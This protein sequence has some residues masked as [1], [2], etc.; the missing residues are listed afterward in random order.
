MN[1][2]KQTKIAEK[3][4]SLL[5][6]G[7]GYNGSKEQAIKEIVTELQSNSLPEPQ[8]TPA[9]RE[10]FMEKM[11]QIQI[12][13]YNK[14]KGSNEADLFTREDIAD[15]VATLAQKEMAKYETAAAFQ[16]HTIKNLKTEIEQQQ[17]ETARLALLCQ[18]RNE[19]ITKLRT[20]NESLVQVAAK[21]TERIGELQ[22]EQ[23]RL[24]AI[25]S[26]GINQETG[27]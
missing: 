5:G 16:E 12:S 7:Y 4:Y 1:T 3:I 2:E 27:K 14:F 26:L 9:T 10:Q 20:E 17:Q 8:M 6:E 23:I 19:Q 24:K 15:Y 25:I 13:N 22:K 18:N 21:D 11:Q